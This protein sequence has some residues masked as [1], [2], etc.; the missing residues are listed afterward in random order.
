MENCSVYGILYVHHADKS[1]LWKRILIPV[2]ARR[3]KEKSSVNSYETNKNNKH[4]YK[5]LS[6]DDPYTLYLIQYVNFY[7]NS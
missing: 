2:H 4:R 3:K 7:P 1:T 6:P 5:N